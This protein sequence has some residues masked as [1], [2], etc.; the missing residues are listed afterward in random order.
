[1]NFAAK[2]VK[3]NFP[4]VRASHISKLPIA[5]LITRMRTDSQYELCLVLGCGEDI[6]KTL[7]S[8]VAKITDRWSWEGT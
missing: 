2:L 6:W 8:A 1:M 7:H 4:V 3:T 5:D